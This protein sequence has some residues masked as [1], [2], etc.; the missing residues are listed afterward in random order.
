MEPTDRAV[1]CRSLPLDSARRAQPTFTPTMA[2]APIERSPRGP[3]PC[4]QPAAFRRWRSPHR[5]ASCSF[6]T[7]SA[8]HRIR[9][10]ANLPATVLVHALLVAPPSCSSRIEMILPT[11][12]LYVPI[13]RPQRPRQ[14][15]GMDRGSP[16]LTASGSSLSAGTPDAVSKVQ[17]LDFP[18][19]L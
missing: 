5:A 6:S 2:P 4:R 8:Q 13:P 14:P 18:I 7:C 9:T 10:W 3:V 15:T 17:V 19:G 1:R 16:T 11:V 12:C